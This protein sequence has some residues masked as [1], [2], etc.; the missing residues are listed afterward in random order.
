[1]DEPRTNA[2]WSKS[3]REKQISSINAYIW[4]VERWYWWTYLWGSSGDTD[5]ENRCVDTVG[6]WEGGTNWES[7]MEAYALPCVK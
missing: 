7:R 2:E 4:N 1:M 6:G 3:E 5:M